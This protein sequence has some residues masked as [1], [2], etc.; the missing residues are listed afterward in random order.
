M[1]LLNLKEA[2]KDLRAVCKA[3]PNDVDAKRQLKAC[4]KE[5]KLREFEKAIKV[6]EVVKTI[7]Q[8]LGNPDDVV[9]PDSYDGPRYDDEITEDY[10][11][12]LLEYQKE[13]KILHK[14]YVYKTV[15]KARKHF[16]KKE[17]L[18]NITI[19][20][21]G[22]ITVCG[23][24]HGQYYDLLHIFEVK[25]VIEYIYYTKKDL[26]LIMNKFCV[27]FLYLDEWKTIPNKYVLF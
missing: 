7:E 17:S 27:E 10:V 19:P 5:Y 20:E 25:N 22:R 24:V 11:N 6:D 15:I 21:N 12:Q 2:L 14:K 23:D 13:Q 4:E 18:V 8:I 26:I 16:E 1:A 9:V 3:A